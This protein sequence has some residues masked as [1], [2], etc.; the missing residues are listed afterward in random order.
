MQGSAGQ[1]KAK[2]LR[3]TAHVSNTKLN[4]SGVACCP[5]LMPLQQLGLLL[6]PFFARLRKPQLDQD[7]P[8]TSS[9]LSS[10]PLL[11]SPTQIPVLACTAPV[12]H[13]GKRHYPPLLPA[14]R[15]PPKVPTHTRLIAP[16]SAFPP[17][18]QHQ[19]SC[20][21]VEHSRADALV[22]TSAPPA[23]QQSAAPEHPAAHPPP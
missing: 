3:Y 22:S 21:I 9:P 16:A 20:S 18:P 13:T 8:P 19:P 11:S 17:T 23:Q 2:T 5:L 14:T 15:C 1:S 10:P 12:S 6:A 7:S 4:P